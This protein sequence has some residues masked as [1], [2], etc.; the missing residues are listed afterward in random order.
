MSKKLIEKGVVYVGR[1]QLKKHSDNIYKISDANGNYAYDWVVG[2]NPYQKEHLNCNDKYYKKLQNL[3]KESNNDLESNFRHTLKVASDTKSDAEKLANHFID[4]KGSI[5]FF[6]ENA[7]IVDEMK[8]S[9]EFKRFKYKLWEKLKKEA[10]KGRIKQENKKGVY[11][12]LKITDINLPYYSPFEVLGKNDDLATFIGGVQLCIANY[13]LYKEKG[14][15]TVYVTQ[16]IFFD[17]FGAGWDDACNTNK[18][19][20]DGLVSMFVLQHYKNIKNPS[21]Y[22][23][24]VIAIV[25]K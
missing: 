6:P 23:P 4:G 12:I 20:S 14:E 18:A 5:F 11:D 2:D 1:N 17:T 3:K 13:E 22:Q 16:H 25:I 8:N 10:Q 7:N 21:K 24:F 9:T 15:Y 19:L